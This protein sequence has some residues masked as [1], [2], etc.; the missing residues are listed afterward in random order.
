MNF[1]ENYFSKIANCVNSLEK[2]T[3]KF[4]EAIEMFNSVSRQS[5]KILL[6]G[7]GGSAAMASHVTVDLIKAAGIRAMN[8]NEADLITCFAN[9]YGYE[10]WVERAIESYGDKGDV[11]ILISSSGNSKNIT[12]AANAA[13]RME[14]KVLTFS[15][16]SPDNPLRNLG[17]INFWAD[18]RDYNVVEMTHHIWLLALVDKYIADNKGA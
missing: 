9:D 14:L 6:T 16:F 17:D 4:D 12:N 2:S 10:H 13:K 18:S 15:G 5:R 1:Y 7:N 11:V 8:F 3:Q